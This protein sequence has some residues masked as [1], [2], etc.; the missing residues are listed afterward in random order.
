MM[1]EHE[2]EKSN[3]VIG[4]DNFVYAKLLTDAIGT[5]PPTYG[6]VKRIPVQYRQRSIRTARLIPIMATTEPYSSPTTRATPKCRWSSRTSTMIRLPNFS[7][8]KRRTVSGLKSLLTSRCILR[9]VSV[10]G[11]AVPIQ[12]ATRFTNTSGSQRESSAYRKAERQP[13]RKA[14]NPSTSR[15]P[16]SSFQLSI[17]RTEWGTV[18]TTRIAGPMIR[19]FRQLGLQTGS[20][21]LSLRS[22][23]TSA[24][25]ADG[26]P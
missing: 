7:D 24:N 10:Y 19:Q 3:P 18:S 6:P 4:L 25:L 2:M 26:K 16:P 17:Q 22:L 8:R 5:T 20:M 14:W 23:A 21:L 11:S 1:E 12:T 13:K 15:L 9:S